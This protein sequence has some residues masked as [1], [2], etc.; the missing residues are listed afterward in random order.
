M[1]CVICVL[2]FRTQILRMN[3]DSFF[4]IM[5]HRYFDTL[6]YSVQVFGM[7]TDFATTDCTTFTKGDESQASSALPTGETGAILPQAEGTVDVATN[8]APPMA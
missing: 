5:G 8:V 3:T 2:F 1:I 4:G 6:R 7:D